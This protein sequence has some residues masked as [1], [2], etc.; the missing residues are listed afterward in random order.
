MLSLHSRLVPT[1]LRKMRIQVISDVHLEM[2]KE[3]Q[4]AQ[5]IIDLVRQGRENNAD[6]LVVAGDVSP[7]PNTR[8]IF[9]QKL[10]LENVWPLGIVFVAG[11]HDYWNSYYTANELDRALQ[12]NKVGVSE[13]VIPG[14][15]VLQRRTL[16][17]SRNDGFD[18]MSNPND[19]K[20]RILGCTLWS[21][22]AQGLSSHLNDYVK[23]QQSRRM[24]LN[25][26]GAQD[27]YIR[28]RD[29]LTSELDVPFDGTTVVV[30]HHGP[31]YMVLSGTKYEHSP[32]NTGYVSNL[33]HLL[34]K[35]NTWIYGHTH[36]LFDSIIK[37]CHI[38][39]HPLGYP[40]E[41]S[42]RPDGFFINV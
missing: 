31:S 13:D 42:V 40:G 34:P 28:D 10:S 6:L 38:V 9:F 27:L 41:L 24:K 26:D 30:T 22:C 4:K 17:L 1:I 2:R 12:D 37:G 7:N 5:L 32:W 33:D 3:T 36:L 11:N 25:Y 20:V 35:A 14:V 16:I 18:S 19:S 21:D 8:A 15:H 29:W 23:I 39:S